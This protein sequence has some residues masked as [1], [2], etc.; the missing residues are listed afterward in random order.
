MFESRAGGRPILRF[1]VTEA[2]QSLSYLVPA[3]VGDQ[4]TSGQLGGGLEGGKHPI[5]R[6]AT[7][8]EL[9]RV[10]P[11]LPPHLVNYTMGLN[12]MMGLK[13]GDSKTVVILR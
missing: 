3:G 5:I 4:V 7:S 6:T 1:D 12:S 13:Q 2:N 10:T 9:Y 11:G 8:G